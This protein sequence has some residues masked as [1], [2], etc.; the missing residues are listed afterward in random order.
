MTASRTVL[1]FI[2]PQRLH[3]A[4]KLLD[5]GGRCELGSGF[6]AD[7]ERGIGSRAIVNTI[8][9]VRSLGHIY[10]S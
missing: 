8:A 3:V 5:L 10:R 2:G 6:R 1:V 4:Q 9:R 7:A